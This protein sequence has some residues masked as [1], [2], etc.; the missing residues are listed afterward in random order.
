MWIQG[1][2]AP[3]SF[4][5][6]TPRHFHLAMRGVRKRLE[7]EGQART[8]QAYETG[9]FAGLAHHGKLKALKHYQVQEKAQ[10]PRAMVAEIQ[11]LG[12]RSNMKV[13][14]VDRSEPAA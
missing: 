14:R 2:F 8:A 11:A 6:Q 10:T 5:Q 3:D 4:W 9:A 12:A 13:K 7:S 1:G